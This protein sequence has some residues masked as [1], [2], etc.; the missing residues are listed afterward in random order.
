MNDISSNVTSENLDIL[1]DKDAALR[2]IYDGQLGEMAGE[3]VYR[4]YDSGILTVESIRDMAFP[5]FDSAISS[6]KYAVHFSRWLEKYNFSGYVT[7]EILGMF[8]GFEY[9]P[10]AKKIA[11]F[12]NPYSDEAYEKFSQK[13]TNPVAVI[14]NSFVGVCEEVSYGRAGYCI[15]PIANSDNGMLTGFYKMMDKY[16]LKIMYT[17]DVTREESG[18]ESRTQMAL[19]R[20]GI[21]KKLCDTGE[22]EFIEISAG[23]G[24][25]SIGYGTAQLGEMMT[26]MEATGA[27]IKRVSSVPISYTDDKFLYNILLNIGRK[28]SECAHNILEALLLFLEFTVPDYSVIGLYG[29]I[30]MVE[31]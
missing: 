19:L 26:A 30:S 31:I 22:G 10:E 25:S 17:C 15:L 3:A 23:F 18:E 2:A 1:R 27:E 9:L 14:A 28:K 11:C 21:S 8:D 24:G 16:D 5:R 13:V 4:M 20:R 7:D 6:A 12:I 29:H